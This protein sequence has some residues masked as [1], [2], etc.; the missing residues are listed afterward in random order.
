VGECTR[1]S[2]INGKGGWEGMGHVKDKEK[3]INVSKR[4]AMRL[5]HSR[6]YRRAFKY[7]VNKSGL[8]AHTDVIKLVWVTM[9]GLGVQ[10]L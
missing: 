4:N 2:T 8:V 9:S 5:A 10:L 7:A 1:A 3:C 6:A